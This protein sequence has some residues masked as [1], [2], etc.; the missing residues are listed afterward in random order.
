MFKKIIMVLSVAMMLIP[1]TSAFAYNGGL[2]DGKPLGTAANLSNLLTT[3]VT[4]ATDGDL[5]TYVSLSPSSGSTSV[6]DHL[7]VKFDEPQ[8]IKYY[9]LKSDA[10]FTIYF[11]SPTKATIKQIST[12]KTDGSITAVD[13]GSIS[14]VG[15]VAVVSKTASGSIPHN[16]YEWDLFNDLPPASYGNLS[17]LVYNVNDKSATFT[18][19]N[20]TNTDVPVKGTN[21]YKNGSLVTTLDTDT[22]VYVDNDLLY[23]TAYTYKFATVYSDNVESDGSITSFLTGSEPPDPTKIPPSNPTNLQVSDITANSAKLTWSNSNDD[24]LASINIY[25]DDGTV[26]TN[27]PISSSYVLSDLSPLTDYKFSIALVDNDGNV[28]GKLPIS[29]T[30]LVGK[31]ETPPVAVTGVV[32]KQ[33]NGALY[34]QWDKS[35]DE[36]LAGYDLYVNGQKVNDSLIKNNFY[37]VPDLENDVEYNIEVVAVDKSGNSSP[38]NE[39]VQ[40]SPSSAAIPVLKTDYSLKDVSDGVSVWFAEYWLIL[41]FAISIPLSFYIA[42]RIKLMFLD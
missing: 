39:T 26:L 29:F 28:S 12:L 27:I 18:W 31:D 9:R 24:D 15:Y 25:K 23:D 19:T 10:D 30:T 2:M 3:G 32:V 1:V 7:Y 38:V 4:A 8:T 35:T 16:V 41:A 14:N 37:T 13:G 40:E 6:P 42:A 17:D 21:V 11:Y 20:P 34:V 33:G 5:D 22:N 36:D